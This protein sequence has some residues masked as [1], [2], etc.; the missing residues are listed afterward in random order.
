VAMGLKLGSVDG[1]TSGD[2]KAWESGGNVSCGR[3]L[4]KLFLVFGQGFVLRG[5]LQKNNK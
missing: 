3:K 2:R 1:V 4:G 5:Q